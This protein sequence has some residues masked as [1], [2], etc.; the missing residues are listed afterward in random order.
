MTACSKPFLL[1]NTGSDRATAYIHGNKCVSRDGKTHVVWTDEIATTCGRTFDHRTGKWSEPVTLGCG[2]DNHNNPSLTM[3]AEGRLHLAYGPHGIWG[4]YPDK[5]P[6]GTFK[7]AISNK[8]NTLDGLQ[9][10]IGGPYPF[11]YRGTYATLL[12]VPPGV[13]CIV[14]RG[15]EHPPSLVFQH[16]AEFGVWTHARCLMSQRLKPQY[17][18]NGAIIA[19]DRRGTIYVAGH[20]YGGDR[21]GG[22]V[23]SMGV[24]ILRSGDLGETWSDLRG[25][26][27]AT[28]IEYDARFAVPHGKPEF[29]PRMN[30]LVIDSRGTVWA[31]TGCRGALDRSLLLSEWQGDRWRTV[32]VSAFLDPAWIPFVAILTIDTRDR[33]HIAL[34]AVAADRRERGPDYNCF[35]DVSSEIF[36]MVSADGG[37]TFSCRQVSVTDPQ[38]P[39]WLPSI[40]LP[41]P[42][43][44]VEQPVI[45]YTTGK[46]AKEAEVWCVLTD[47][48]GA[49][50]GGGRRA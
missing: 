15:G 27:A 36:H 11:G 44:P 32:D 31:L 45:L 16:R 13:D 6:A 23:Y 1:S 22:A 18:H 29:D 5:W 4:I 17:T 24:A 47:P 20:F 8:P 14:Y 19:A 33:L 26:P 28:P 38:R 10:T 30:G 3:D 7:Y 25:A 37:R 48:D 41:G 49:G 50:G 35:G 46:V 42:F 9:E 21:P 40:S 2:S 39:N 43:H 12:N 34:T